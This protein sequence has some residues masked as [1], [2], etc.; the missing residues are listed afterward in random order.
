MQRAQAAQAQVEA[1]TAQ[2]RQQHS[3]AVHAAAQLEEDSASAGD[4]ACMQDTSLVY[5]PADTQLISQVDCPAVAFC[6]T[7]C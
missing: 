2:G 4:A 5:N 7:L 3:H 6:V 1:V